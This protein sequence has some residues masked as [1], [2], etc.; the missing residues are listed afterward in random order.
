MTDVDR[1]GRGILCPFQRDGKGDFAN[2]IGLRLLKSDIGELLGIYGPVVATPGEL[3]WDMDRGSGLYRLKH[4]LGY[5]EMTQARAHQ[6]ISG[7]M[8]KYEPRVRVGPTTVTMEE[9]P[10]SIR[11][12]A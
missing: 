1:F 12:V 2:G 9:A 3:P 4:R 5:S 10:G 6:Y 11:F 8:N 7:T